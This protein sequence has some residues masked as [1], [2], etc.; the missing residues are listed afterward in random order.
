MS[1]TI[2]KKITISLPAKLVEDYKK[3]VDNNAFNMSG[4]IA[5]LIKEDLNMKGNEN[6]NK[7]KRR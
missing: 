3:F 7:I 1:K 6:E 2:Y 5:I 4:R